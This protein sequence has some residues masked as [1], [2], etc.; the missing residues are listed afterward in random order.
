MSD[1]IRICDSDEVVVDYDRSTGKYRVSL[2]KDGHFQ[3]EW[4]F[5]EYKGD[6]RKGGTE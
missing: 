5:D 2:F 1:L 4:W 3:D 6:V